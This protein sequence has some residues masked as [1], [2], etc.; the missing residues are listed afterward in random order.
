MSE[1]KEFST[2]AVLSVSS[3]RLLTQPSDKS[4]DNG[5]GQVYEVLEWMTGDPPFTHQL[6]Q[7]AEKCKPRIH[8]WHPAII[9]IDVEIDRRC[10]AGD[11]E[12]VQRDMV[13]M[14]GE[15]FPLQRI[16]KTEVVKIHNRWQHNNGL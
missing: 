14:F 1:M 12:G 5:I 9:E 8:K 3:G 15:T 16:P 13:A 6:P 10:E 7:F 2:L 11:V 4:E